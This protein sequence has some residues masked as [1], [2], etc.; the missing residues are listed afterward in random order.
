MDSDELFARIDDGLRVQVKG[1]QDQSP[2]C[3]VFWQDEG[4]VFVRGPIPGGDPDYVCVDR[5][6]VQDFQD[7]LSKIY[8]QEKMT[9]Y[10]RVREQLTNVIMEQL[11]NQDQS[12]QNA[13]DTSKEYSKQFEFPSVLEH[14]TFPEAKTA[15]LAYAARVKTEYDDDEP[16]LSRAMKLPDWPQFK[17]AIRVEF[18]SVIVKNNAFRKVLFKDIPRN[19]NGERKIYPLMILLKRKRDQMREI[20]KHKCK[21]LMNGSEAIF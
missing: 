20:K 12:K 15:K 3:E 1:L 17:E 5:I 6:T 9:E 14:D 7:Q 8:E 4:E 16:T 21:L 13:W 18:T 10:D 11:L 19:A 2:T